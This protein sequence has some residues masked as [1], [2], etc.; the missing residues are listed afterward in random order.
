MDCCSYGIPCDEGEGD[1]DSDEECKP[2]LI[3]GH[4]NCDDI[5]SKTNDNSTLVNDCCV[6]PKDGKFINF[7]SY[8]YSKP[9]VC[10]K[11][12]LSFR[13]FYF[14]FSNNSSRISSV[15]FY[16]SKPEAKLGTSICH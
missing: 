15:V 13:C 3:C 12:L 4:N 7:I 6:F 2:G 16:S 14:P 8:L 11:S 9:I 1:C 10:Y 5:V